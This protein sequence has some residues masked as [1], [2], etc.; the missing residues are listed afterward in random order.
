[1]SSGLGMHVLRQR[2][3]RIPTL[4]A[5]SS[6]SL[7]LVPGLICLPGLEICGGSGAPRDKLH[8]SWPSLSV[9]LEV[10]KKIHSSHDNGSWSF[11][12]SI[13]TKPTGFFSLLLVTSLVICS[14]VFPAQKWYIHLTPISSLLANP[15][16]DYRDIA[17]DYGS[18]APTTGN[19]FALASV[20]NNTHPQWWRDPGLRKLNILLLSSFLG[21]IANGYD[22]S[23]ISGLEAIP[24][25]FDDLGGLDNTNT[26][27]LLIAAYSFEA[28]SRSSQHHGWP[29]S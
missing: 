13:E 12:S 2:D 22:V 3:P 11:L 24:R 15:A 21:S 17:C 5:F 27:G 1:M 26:F 6:Q 19:I 10:Y 4:T 9:K 25:W 8:Q 20:P 14:S 7:S 29:T 28:S 18:Q 16:E 23:L